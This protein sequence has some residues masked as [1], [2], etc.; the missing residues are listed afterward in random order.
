MRH[1]LLVVG[2]KSRQDLACAVQ[3]LA[4]PRDVAVPEYGPRAGEVAHRG[5]AVVD[6]LIGQIAHRG[7]SGGE[8]DPRHVCG[9][10]GFT[11]A[12]SAA[13]GA[14]QPRRPADWRR[15]QPPS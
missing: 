6:E 14:M 7:L 11:P 3:R 10:L 8:T 5:V 13:P 15:A 1:A 9:S 4:E 2:A 12:D